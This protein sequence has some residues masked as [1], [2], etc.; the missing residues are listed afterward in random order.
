MDNYTILLPIPVMDPDIISILTTS[1]LESFM[2]DG[3]IIIRPVPE[4]EVKAAFGGG[5]FD[6]DDF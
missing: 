1:V 5:G 6:D 4:E 3:E 2:R